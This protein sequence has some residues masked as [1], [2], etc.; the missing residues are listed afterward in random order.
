MKDISK[1]ELK[2]PFAKDTR[3]FD[4]KIDFIENSVKLK[5]KLKQINVSNSDSSFFCSFKTFKKGIL[6]VIENQTPMSMKSKEEVIETAKAYKKLYTYN[7]NDLSACTN[8]DI[9][10]QGSKFLNQILH[11]SNLNHLINEKI[12]NTI[13]TYSNNANKQYLSDNKELSNMNNNYPIKSNINEN[14]TTKANKS[15]HHNFFN[16]NNAN[17]NKIPKLSI[18]ANNLLNDYITSKD[19]INNTYVNELKEFNKYADNIAIRYNIKNKYKDLFKEKTKNN[20]FSFQV[21]NFDKEIQEK[22]VPVNKIRFIEDSKF[23]LFTENIQK[24]QTSVFKEN[25]FCS[26]PHFNNRN[27]NFHIND[28]K[29]SVE[30]GIKWHIS[31]YKKLGKNII[32]LKSYLLYFTNKEY[33]DDNLIKTNK[34]DEEQFKDNNGFIQNNKNIYN[35]NNFTNVNQNNDLNYNTNSIGLKYNNH[36]INYDINT[37]NEEKYKQYKDTFENFS[38]N[39]DFQNYAKDFLNRTQEEA[40]NLNTQSNNSGSKINLAIKEKAFNSS[41][42]EQSMSKNSENN[43]TLLNY[44][45]NSNIVNITPNNN[46]INTNTKN[47]EENR[48]SLFND[49]LFQNIKKYNVYDNN[50]IKDNNSVVNNNFETSQSNDK[51]IKLKNRIMPAFN[52][53]SNSLNKK[54]STNDNEIINNIKIDINNNNSVSSPNNKTKLVTKNKPKLSIQSIQ[55]NNKTNSLQSTILTNDNKIK[56][57]PCINY[58]YLNKITK[59]NRFYLYILARILSSFERFLELLYNKSENFKTIFNEFCSSFITPGDKCISFI[60]KKDYIHNNINYINVVN[61]NNILETNLYTNLNSNNH[62]H[63]KDSLLFNQKI[64][65]QKFSNLNQFENIV[66][67]EKFVSF[68][69]MFS[70]ASEEESQVFN[71][72]NETEIGIPGSVHFDRIFFSLACL[73]NCDVDYISAF[74]GSVNSVNVNNHIHNL[75]Y[76]L[77]ANANNKDN[78]NINS[79][80]SHVSLLKSDKLYYHFKELLLGYEY[81][82]FIFYL[83]KNKEFFLFTNI[84]DSLYKL[85]G[86]IGQLK[87]L[88]INKEEIKDIFPNLK[89][90]EIYKQS[91]FCMFSFKG[92][93]TIFRYEKNKINKYKR[94]IDQYQLDK[95]TFKRT[96]LVEGNFMLENQ[97]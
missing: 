30:T 15:K 94:L 60:N 8:N 67:S 9:I 75:N 77:S 11:F 7:R 57:N 12:T 29:P 70:P 27:L 96:K 19:S 58:N 38:S 49:D 85:S 80:F 64:L 45:P 95:E 65:I 88:M 18:K 78:M 48:G 22:W 72:L 33:V 23:D 13:D 1:K 59:K 25:D 97:R 40:M 39:N 73:N 86:S 37:I 69:D 92:L 28:I 47:N 42:I 89:M 4:Y 74:K 61:S 53:I 24:I 91:N 50:S 83:N 10:I 63:S 32:N 68:L 3:V 90:F 34:N 82:P 56:S 52:N 17:V 14:K 6:T 81:L 21:K 87:M 62:N 20:K 41:L 2:N 76:N 31:E 79:N 54:T 66:E 51:S 43:D 5:Y 36:Y 46:V 93:T 16:I 44:I 26:M 84:N 55:Q 35:N 71:S